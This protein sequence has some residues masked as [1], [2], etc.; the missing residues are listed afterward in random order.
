MSYVTIESL[1]IVYMPLYTCIILV[2]ADG[3]SITTYLWQL[4]L[5]NEVTK[6]SGPAKCSCSYK[7]ILNYDHIEFILDDEI[8]T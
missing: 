3:K 7:Y 1:S 2:C 5:E 8:C 4:F 6:L